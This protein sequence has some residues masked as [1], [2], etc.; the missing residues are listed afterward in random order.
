MRWD[1]GR[2]Q[3]TLIQRPPTSKFQVG[4]VLYRNITSSC[5]IESFVR[6]TT[7]GAPG[8]YRQQT[9]RI[10]NG[11]RRVVISGGGISTATFER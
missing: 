6:E 8:G 5:T 3:G 11:G 10:E 7:T 2:N 9:V 1:V 4:D